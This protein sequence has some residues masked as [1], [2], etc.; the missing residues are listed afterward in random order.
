MKNAYCN[1]CGTRVMLAE[2]GSCANG[3]PRSA[4]RDVREGA[5]AAVPA[6]D[7]RPISSGR[8]GL[9]AGAPG[10]NVVSPNLP[11]AHELASKIIGG[12]IVGVPTALVVVF[13]LWS[14]YAG[15]LAMGTT[16][17]TAWLSS[18][19]SLLLTGAMVALWVAKRRMRH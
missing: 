8:T 18:I 3:H 12:M 7:V 4:L 9:V 15:S 19:G 13:A 17:A 5:L 16:R 2:D 1:E 6:A 11:P 14:G 10:P